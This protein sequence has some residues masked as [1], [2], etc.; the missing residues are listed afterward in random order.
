MTSLNVGCD[1]GPVSKGNRYLSEKSDDK[2]MVQYQKALELDNK[3]P[4]AY[5]GLAS[6]YSDK[7]EIAKARDMIG[8]GLKENPND[9]ALQKAQLRIFG[10]LSEFMNQLT[11]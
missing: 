4:K 9:E 7:G 8:E 10:T 1:N 6:V 11:N 3:N 5:L 2:A